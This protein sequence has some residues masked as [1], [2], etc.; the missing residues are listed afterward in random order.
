MSD[1]IYSPENIER[2][3]ARARGIRAMVEDGKLGR[4]W[5]DFATE[6]ERLADERESTG[7]GTTS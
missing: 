4:E 6:V 3:R 7:S 5:L 1:D 2:S